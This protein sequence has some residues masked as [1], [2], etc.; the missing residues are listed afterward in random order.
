MF[1]NCGWKGPCLECGDDRVGA[2][3]ISIVEAV[4]TIRQSQ[5]SFVLLYRIL[6]VGGRGKK[7]VFVTSDDRASIQCEGM[8]DTK[9]GSSVVSGSGTAIVSAERNQ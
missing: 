6:P 5:Y 2:T 1:G 4:I 7:F 8:G 3:G 9:T